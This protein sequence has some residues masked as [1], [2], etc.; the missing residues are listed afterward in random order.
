V[1]QAA[2]GEMLAC[3]AL[4]EVVIDAARSRY[5]AWRREAWCALA[6]HGEIATVLS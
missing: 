5:A 6:S 1:L 4:H 3:R 2:R